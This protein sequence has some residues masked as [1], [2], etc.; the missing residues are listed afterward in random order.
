ME[1]TKKWYQS[2]NFWNGV[3]LALG[4]LVVG[5]PH[6]AATDAVSAIFALVAAGFAVRDGLTGKR[7]NVKDW[8]LNPNTWRNIGV[9]IVSIV[10]LFPPAVATGV[11]DVISAALGGNWQ[12]ILTALFA[13]GTTLYFWLKPNKAVATSRTAKD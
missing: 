12:G 10:P 11:G 3:I 13:L 5:F 7:L 1:P 4:G 8:A 6:E 9:V 2:T